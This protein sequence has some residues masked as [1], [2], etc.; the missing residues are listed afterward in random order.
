MYEWLTFSLLL[1]GVWFAIFA[2]VPRVRREM[3]WVGLFT[4]PF[5]LTEP[6]FVPAYWNPPSL[7]NLAA[8]TG[9][10]I[11]SFIFLFAAGGI[12]S[13]LYE[14]AVKATH[15]KMGVE[16]IKK[17]DR[18]IHLAALASPIV[19]FIALHALTGMNVIYSAILAMLAGG[20]AAVACRPDLRNK[21]LTGGIL[22]LAFYFVYF[23]AFTL[24]YPGIVER[25][26]NLAALSGILVLGVPLEELMFAFSFGM[27]WSSAYE[28]VMRYKYV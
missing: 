28:H 4:M 13:V 3:F 15:Q 16:E 10:D 11:E 25:V 19:V 18:R 7:F 21:V 5:G 24:T 14:V 20:V 26:W 17:E 1:F 12:G 27:L 6:L 22:F 8:R 2:A 23:L 9:F